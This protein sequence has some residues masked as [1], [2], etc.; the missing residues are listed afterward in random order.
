MLFFFDS[1]YGYILAEA[2]RSL[3]LQ[4]DSV[5]EIEDHLWLGH[6][7]IPRGCKFCVHKRA[8]GLALA[9]M[10]VLAAVSVCEHTINL[11]SNM[12]SNR[13]LSENADVVHVVNDLQD[14]RTLPFVRAENVF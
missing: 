1:N 3:S 11:P 12:G 14:V 9:N 13:D 8:F 5:H 7:I 2:T 4:D 6:T 10:G